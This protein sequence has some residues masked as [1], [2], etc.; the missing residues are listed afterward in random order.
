MIGIDGADYK[1]GFQNQIGFGT[2]IGWRRG[3][4]DETGSF[5]GMATETIYLT[6]G[7]KVLRCEGIAI[8]EDESEAGWLDEVFAEWE[9]MIEAGEDGYTQV[10]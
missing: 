1:F 6:D 10:K 3:S 5:N 8:W 4:D 9:E 2:D 7:K